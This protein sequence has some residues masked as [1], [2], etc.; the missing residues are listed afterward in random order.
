MVSFS[1]SSNFVGRWRWPIGLGLVP[2]VL[3]IVP[4]PAQPQVI[5]RPQIIIL[6]PTYRL[7]PRQGR[8]LLELV[9]LGDA[10]ATVWIDGRSVFRPKNFDRRQVIEL[11]PGAYR[12]VITGITRN[13]IWAAGYLDVKQK[14]NILRLSFS[15]TGEVQVQ[16]DPTAWLPDPDLNPFEVWQ[17]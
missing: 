2:I 6:G 16:N 1:R 4:L 13:Q 11:E 3:T 5:I 17:R 15:E 14:T 8:T 9:A 12:V 7:L 10:W